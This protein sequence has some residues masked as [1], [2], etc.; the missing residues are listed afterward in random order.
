MAQKNL[1]CAKQLQS[2]SAWKLKSDVYADKSENEDDYFIRVWDSEKYRVLQD[3][4][5]INADDL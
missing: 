4:N 5:I 2:Q 1:T 3:V